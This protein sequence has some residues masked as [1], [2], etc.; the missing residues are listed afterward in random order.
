MR[1]RDLAEEATDPTTAPARLAQ[2][3]YSMDEG[4]RRAARSN[5][6]LPTDTLLACLEVGSPEAWRNPAL[7]FLLF[8]SQVPDKMVKG[9]LLLARP[10]LV[11]PSVGRLP[12]DL[13]EPVTTALNL[14]WS[15]TTDALSMFAL[16]VDMAQT[17]G[18]EAQ[19]EVVRFVLLPHQARLQRRITPGDAYTVAALQMVDRWGAGAFVST[20]ARTAQA[21]GVNKEL[22]AARAHLQVNGQP[23]RKTM[24]VFAAYGAGLVVGSLLRLFTTSEGKSASDALFRSLGSFLSIDHALDSGTVLSPHQMLGGS[25]G[26]VAELAPTVRQ[27]WPSF[28]WSWDEL[29]RSG[30]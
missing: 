22:A 21:M 8:S 16:I 4:E 24:E 15:T 2:L 26:A 10:H 20:D 25:G 17:A 28:A 19:R 5:P 3:A 13:E 12:P 23:Q 11:N 1:P 30:R 29:E 27:R 14:W 18:E 9:A 6:N 7:P